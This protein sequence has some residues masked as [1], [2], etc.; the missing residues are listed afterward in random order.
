[1]EGNYS[2]IILLACY[3]AGMVVGTWICWWF[4]FRRK[5]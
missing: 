1:M 3:G 4:M 5:K 2:T